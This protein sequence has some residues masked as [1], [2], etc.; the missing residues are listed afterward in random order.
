MKSISKLG[1]YVI[2]IVE[3]TSDEFTVVA[4][5]LMMDTGDRM[6]I[7]ESQHKN[8]K[9]FS[10][11]L[12]VEAYDALN[13]QQVQFCKE[14]NESASIYSK[15]GTINSFLFIHIPVTE[16]V[17]AVQEAMNISKDIFTSPNDFL[18]EAKKISFS[19]S[20]ESKYW[21]EGH[22]SFDVMHE[23]I[24]CTKYDDLVFDRIKNFTSLIVAG[25]E[26]VN[27]FVIKHEGTVL[28]YSMKTDYESICEEDM[29][30]GTVIKVS[31][32]NTFTV[33]HHLYLNQQ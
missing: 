22:E 29:I 13:N 33:S 30:G 25:H 23:Q 27:N 2:N 3:K 32:D 21:K 5:L 19:D 31:S 11:P 9:V 20:Y 12:L 28:C 7:D 1:N 14:C 17:T 15:T 4:S 10:K 8:E 18:N 24:C 16:Y 6:I 26:H